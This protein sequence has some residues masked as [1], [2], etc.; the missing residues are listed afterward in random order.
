MSLTPGTWVEQGALSVRRERGPAE[1]Y[2]VEFYGEL[3]LGSVECAASELRCCA[4]SDVEEII[5]DL[6]GLDFIDS[7]GLGVLVHAY[8][9]D[10]EN[11]NRLRFLRGSAPVQRV[12]E[13]TSLDTVLPFAD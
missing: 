1:L 10:R 13:L 3:D 11:G 9:S 5:V 8:R 12:M 2:V 4:D 7:T 6:S